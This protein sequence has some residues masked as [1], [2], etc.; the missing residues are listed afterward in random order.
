MLEELASHDCMLSTTRLR[1]KLNNHVY[2]YLGCLEVIKPIYE[3]SNTKIL[4]ETKRTNDHEDDV[5]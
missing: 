1:V 5:R 3:S 4:E 2:K